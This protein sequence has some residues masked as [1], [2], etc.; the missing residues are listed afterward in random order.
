[1][2]IQCRRKLRFGSRSRKKRQTCNWEFLQRRNLANALT[3]KMDSLDLRRQ[4]SSEA[5]CRK[6]R[7]VG[8]AN[9]KGRV[10]RTATSM[11]TKVAFI[12]P[13]L[14]LLMMRD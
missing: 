5:L 4:A 14:G 8:D 9:V 3:P 7:L 13:V 2:Q 10:A 11:K 6:P 12:L 1:V